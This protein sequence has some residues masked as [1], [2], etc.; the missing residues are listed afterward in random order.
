M[1]DDEDDTVGA[2]AVRVSDMSIRIRTGDLAG[3][4]AGLVREGLTFEC[5]PD[6]DGYRIYLLGGY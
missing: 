4:V 2:P 6:V 3:V 1:R 5:V